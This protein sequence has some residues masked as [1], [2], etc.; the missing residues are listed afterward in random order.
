MKAVLFP[1]DRQVAVVERPTPKP[2]PGRRWCGC[3]P[4]PFAANMSLYYGK[5]IV[6][7]EATATGQIVP[8]TSQRVRSSRSVM[9][10]PLS[11]T[12][13][14]PSH[15]LSASATASL[16]PRLSLPLPA[17]QCVGF[18]VDGGNADYIVVPAGNC[19]PL[20]TRSAFEAGV[21]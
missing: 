1:G 14:S 15:L 10:S 8:G 13:G 3:G 18:D 12:W 2:G 20:P 7:G 4:R 17:W 11:T 5:P 21:R 19:L 16:P 6:G 9:V